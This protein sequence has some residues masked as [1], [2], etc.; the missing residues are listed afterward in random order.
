MSIRLL[1]LS[2]LLFLLLSCSAHSLELEWDAGA[3]ADRDWNNPTNWTGNVEPGAL[4]IASV[5][6]SYTAVVSQANEAALDLYVGNSGTATVSQTAGALTLDGKLV[7]GENHGDLGTYTVTG[8]VLSVGSTTIVGVAGIGMMTGTG[9]ATVIASDH[10]V[11]GQGISGA[12][13]TGST[14]TVA[15]GALHVGKCLQIGNDAGADGTVV[16][17][18]GLLSVTDLVMIGNAAFSTGT[19]SVTGGHLVGGGAAATEH[20]LV[21]N[22]GQGTMTISGA[23][24]VTVANSK[25][26]IIGADVG[27]ADGTVNVQGGLLDVGRQL[28]LGNAA[29]ADGSLTVSDGTVGIST[30]AWI[31]N[32]VGSTGSVTLTGGTVTNAAGN[33]TIGQ[34]GRGTLTVSIGATL[35]VTGTAGDGD[36]VVGALSSEDNRLNVYGGAVDVADSIVVAQAAQTRG[37]VLVTNGTVTVPEDVIL[38]SSSTGTMTMVDGTI[39]V[40]DDLLVG[41]GNGGDGTLI[42]SNGIVDVTD[43]IHIGSLA[44]SEGS[45][46]MTGGRL[47]ADDELRIGSAG[48]GSMVISGT[49]TVVLNTATALTYIAYDA[50]STG[51]L[52]VTGGYLEM[53]GSLNIGQGDAGSM[54]VSGGTFY[55]VTNDTPYLRV[56]AGAIGT[57]DISGGT[58]DVYRVYVADQA[59]AAG[60]RFTIDGGELTIRKT[61]GGGTLSFVAEYDSTIEISAGTINAS[62]YVLARYGNATVNVDFSGGTINGNHN[63]NVGAGDGETCVFTQTGGT[64]DLDG[65]QGE[66][67]IGYDVDNTFGYYTITGGVISVADNLELGRD[68]AG[69]TGVLH[70]VGSVP[71]ITVGAG[72]G[73]GDF[74][75]RGNNAELWMTFMDS[76]IETIDVNG[77]VGLN[78]TLTVSNETAINAGEYV[79]L[80]SLTE[81][82]SSV[83]DATNWAGGVEG[84][85][86][87]EN[88]FVK[89]VFSS[90][91]EV[92]GTN[93]ALVVASGDTTPSLADGTDFGPVERPGSLGH[94]FT[95]TNRD[96]TYTLT[97][98]GTPV[99]VIGGDHAAD[100]V[101]TDEPDTN[102]PAGTGTVFTIEFTPSATGARTA[103][104]SI[105]NND[106][107]ETENPY[108]F[109]VT[110]EGAYAPEPAL[111]AS[112]M[113]FTAVTNIAMTVSWTNGAGAKRTLVAK[114]SSDVV[115][116]PLD[117]S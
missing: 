89:L 37:S 78:G 102:L 86:V 115:D 14:L 1:F 28:I 44:G 41:Y 63:F 74:N 6:G 66:L 43:M 106:L 101:V 87:Y 50:G 103:L 30:H 104:V 47:E 107:S 45:L 82:V 116:I 10:V 62:E 97:L 76:K 16:Q 34:N 100:F 35:N 53:P 13:D 95:I 55:M 84:K 39:T 88:E 31:G 64:L 33:F 81:T 80:T 48:A 21:G 12:E 111:D 9:T 27:G 56:G 90:E 98:T 46:T 17:S 70:V 29:A 8:G 114:A 51:S 23:S 69:G 36:I 112:N 26:L 19:L 25:D 60:S 83:F 108:T 18:G 42:I 58:V 85:V 67:R 73:S 92:R 71:D 91:M 72:G 77:I 54:T 68:A 22:S 99:V 96:A 2:P 110:G 7:L 40:G 20:F 24:T 113:V 11:V 38:G 93:E 5:N 65:E 57:L 32:A 4:D 109:A 59:G 105:A 117:G 79:I 49:A 61:T 52:D 75:M 94:T 3:A 15:D